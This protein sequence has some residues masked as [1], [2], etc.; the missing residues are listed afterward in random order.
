MCLGSLD[1]ASESGERTRLACWRWR[2]R[3]RELFSFR[4]IAA[5]RRNE[6]ARRVRSPEEITLT[7]IQTRPVLFSR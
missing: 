2:P 5:R 3:H 1:V 6:H 4:C 7:H